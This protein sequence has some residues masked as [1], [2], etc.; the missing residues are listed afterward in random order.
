MV[1]RYSLL[2]YP[3]GAVFSELALMMMIKTLF[4]PKEGTDPKIGYA[5]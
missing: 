1:S 2:F 3:G 5:A 4:H